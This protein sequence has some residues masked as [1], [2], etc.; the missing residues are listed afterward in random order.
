VQPLV[1][2]I[3]GPL[4]SQRATQTTW[5]RC[6]ATAFTA[7]SPAPDLQRMESLEFQFPRAPLDVHLKFQLFSYGFS[8]STPTS[9]FRNRRPITSA[10]R[11]YYTISNVFKL[12][13]L[14]QI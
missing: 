1:R 11:N 6:F 14:T 2:F 4:L 12:L 9:L 3:M 5:T 13:C 10:W 8:T 7:D